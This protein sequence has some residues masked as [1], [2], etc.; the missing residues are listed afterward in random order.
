VRFENKNIFFYYEKRS[1]L[2]TAL[3]A[4]VVVAN[5]EVIGLSSGCR[6]SCC[7]TIT[8][9]LLFLFMDEMQSYFDLASTGDFF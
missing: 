6:T 8:S 3:N 4:G 2:H 7:W 1:S 9:T 5:F